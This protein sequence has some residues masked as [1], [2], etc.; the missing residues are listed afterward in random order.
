MYNTGVRSAKMKKLIILSLCSLYCLILSGCGQNNN[1]DLNRFK[2]HLSK[3]ETK[4]KSVEKVMN[5]LELNR[6]NDISTVSYT[7][8]TLPTILLV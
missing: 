1:E 8:L 6:L 4:Q 7:H 2:Q 5:Q 3:V